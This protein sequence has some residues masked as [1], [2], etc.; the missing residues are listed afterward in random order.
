MQLIDKMLV[1]PKPQ[2]LKKQILCA[3]PKSLI[4]TVFLD[5]KFTFK[6]FQFSGDMY[7]HFATFFLALYG[8]C[9]R[10]S[11][12]M[13]FIYKPNWARQ[14]PAAHSPGR[15]VWIYLQSPFQR[16]ERIFLRSGRRSEWQ[17]PKSSGSI[18]AIHC[19]W[20]SIPFLESQITKKPAH[21]G[22]LAFGSG[23]RI[24]IL[25]SRKNGL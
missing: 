9:V 1:F 8:S 20:S 2:T 24:R 10:L 22:E 13:P 7:F 16:A 6:L 12:Q 3:S 11:L 19:A 23:R 5:D 25:E 4:C 15:A 14:S 21:L 18:R 17:S